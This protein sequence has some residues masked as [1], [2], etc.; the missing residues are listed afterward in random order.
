M[1]ESHKYAEQ[2]NSCRCMYTCTC[3]IVI[4]NI[5]NILGLHPHFLAH[6]A[7]TFGIS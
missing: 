7:Q 4:Y 5:K 3:D 2:K 6:S 1:I